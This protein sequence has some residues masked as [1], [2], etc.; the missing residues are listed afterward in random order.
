LIKLALM[1]LKPWRSSSPGPAEPDAI[2]RAYT[3]G[4][5]APRE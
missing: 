5:F 3:T 2:F 4:R 1:G